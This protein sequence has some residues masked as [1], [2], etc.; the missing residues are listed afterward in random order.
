LGGLKGFLGYKYF[1]QR[2]KEKRKEYNVLFAF[3]FA[4][5]REKTI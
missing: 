4:P 2:R 5:L 1:T 3:F